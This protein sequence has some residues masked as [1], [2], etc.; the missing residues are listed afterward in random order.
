MKL[1]N[2]ALFIVS[3]QWKTKGEFYTLD[4]RMGVLDE[5]ALLA[6]AKTGNEF[7]NNVL[8]IY[9]WQSLHG[10]HRRLRP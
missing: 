3:E 4:T 7:L 9:F 10:D 1:K 2:R 5:D 6:S 8:K